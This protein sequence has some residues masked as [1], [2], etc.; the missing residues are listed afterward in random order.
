VGLPITGA[1][2]L[3]LSHDGQLCGINEPGEIVLRTPFR[4]LGYLNAPEETQKRFVQN[5]FREDPDDLVYFTG[6]AGRYRPDGTLE[7]LGRFD[8]Q[9]KIRGVRV[10]PAEV[11]AILLQ[12][13]AVTSCVVVGRRNECGETCLVAY[14]VTSEP[15][16]LTPGQLRSYLLDR[17]PSPMV[18]STFVFL[19]VLPL[20]PNGKVDRKALPEPAYRKPEAENGFVAPRNRLEKTIADIW[21]E[22]LKI[23]RIGVHDNFFEAGGHS[24]LAVR[25]LSRVMQALQLN[26]PL[27]ILFE[28]PTVAHLAKVIEQK[29]AQMMAGDLEQLLRELE[30]M[31]EKD[32]QQVLANESVCR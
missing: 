23:E 6:D 24:L 21:A 16:S 11:T 30:T 29:R 18:P 17:L 20:T 19:N 15:N 7:I 26:L 10:E 13:P 8:D 4:C 9:V 5:P 28:F 32:A 1:Q 14:A 2:S 3:V 22:V 12:H 31:P 25:V 27:K